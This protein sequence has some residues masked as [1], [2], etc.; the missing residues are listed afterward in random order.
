[1]GV[2]SSDEGIFEFAKQMDSNRATKPRM[3]PSAAL[4]QSTSNIR[5]TGIRT[6][7][8]TRAEREESLAS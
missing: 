4:S 2:Q 7:S 5:N 6:R 3:P 1:M 8:V